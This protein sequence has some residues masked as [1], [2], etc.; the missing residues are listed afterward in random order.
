MK[1]VIFI[2]VIIAIVLFIAFRLLIRSVNPERFTTSES[3]EN[4]RKQ[5]TLKGYDE[6]IKKDYIVKS[7]DGYELH[8][9][10]IP[11]D[12][13]KIVII[14]HGHTATKWS[15]V[16]YVMLFRKLGYGA[17]IY[18]NR[19]HGDNIRTYM[20]LGLKESKDLIAII[21]DTK[22]KLGSDLFIGLHG[23]SMGSA[24]NNMALKYKPKIKFIISDCGYADFM[25][26]GKAYARSEY[27]LFGGIVNIS[28]WMCKLHYKFDLEDVKPIDLISDNEIPICFIHG[29]QDTLINKINAETM[30]KE[31]LGYKEIHIFEGAK[32]AGSYLKDPDKYY[33]IVN[34][35]VKK[36][37]K[38]NREY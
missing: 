7:F 9:T 22:K 18:D 19:G 12:S 21:E 10:Y 1:W 15:S 14:T 23:E 8:A 34:D 31:N 29:D 5:G 28:N 24:I 4:E 35:F 32:H 3:I 26:M 17:V 6:L 20:T 25:K 16:K 33:E 13:K 11:N 2:L 36:V 37:E 27:R 38:N 30:F